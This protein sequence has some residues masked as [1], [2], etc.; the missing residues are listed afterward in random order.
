MSKKDNEDYGKTKC[1]YFKGV[2]NHKTMLSLVVLW[3]FPQ[4]QKNMRQISTQ[5]CDLN[6]RK[7][8]KT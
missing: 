6:Y 2:K 5:K 4:Q 8:H 3:V 1:C 7:K